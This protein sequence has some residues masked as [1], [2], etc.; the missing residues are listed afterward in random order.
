LSINA[1]AVPLEVTAEFWRAGKRVG[2]DKNGISVDTAPL[3]DTGVR[4]LALVGMVIDVV[5]G[6]WSMQ[7][8]AHEFTP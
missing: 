5:S 8:S 4:E 6:Q 1:K 3:K 2:L 7:R